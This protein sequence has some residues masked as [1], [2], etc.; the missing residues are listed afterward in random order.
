LANEKE[1]KGIEN[2]RDL[3]RG[4]FCFRKKEDLR[5]IFSNEQPQRSNCSRSG[6]ASAV[7]GQY[8]HGG[9]GDNSM[10]P[11]FWCEIA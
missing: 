2:R 3:R 4:G 9:F 6:E 5:A 1:T 7:P 11:V 10:P 8:F